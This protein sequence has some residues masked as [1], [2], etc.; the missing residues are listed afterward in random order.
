MIYMSYMIYITNDVTHSYLFTNDVTHS[1]V[2]HDSFMSDKIQ[3]AIVCTLFFDRKFCVFI[4]QSL[5]E[6]QKRPICD[7]THSYVT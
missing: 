2:W 5:D 1:Y 7:M 4:R 6:F 3:R